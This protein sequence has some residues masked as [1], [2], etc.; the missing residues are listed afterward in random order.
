[1]L[2]GE[3]INI[4]KDILSIK[5]IVKNSSGVTLQ[6]TQSMAFSAEQ[7]RHTIYSQ[8]AEDKGNK[9]LFYYGGTNYG[10]G[11]GSIKLKKLN[12]TQ[13]SWEYL[14]NDIILDDSKCPPGTDINITFQKQK[15]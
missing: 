10:V 14:T 3:N 4:I 8:W 1:M 2:T 11:W 12:A 7:L 13:I 15:I 9:L 6:D 5:F